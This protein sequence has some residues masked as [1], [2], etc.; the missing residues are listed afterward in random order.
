MVIASSF[1]VSNQL[2]KSLLFRLFDEVFDWGQILVMHD[3]RKGVSLGMVLLR[4]LFKLLA[5]LVTFNAPSLDDIDNQ[6]VNNLVAD[7][8]LLLFI[9]EHLDHLTCC[10]CF[11]QDR[12]TASHI[13]IPALNHDFD[14]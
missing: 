12:H 11:L 7:L 8:G 5:K 14:D 6:F 13:D 2:F 10:C 9:C 3:L 1:L 4:N